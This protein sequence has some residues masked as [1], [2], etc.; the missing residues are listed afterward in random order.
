MVTFSYESKT[1]HPT[2]RK[3]ILNLIPK[4]NKDSRYIKN[5]RPITLLNT[6]YKII[7]K[8][9]ANKMIPALKTLIHE[10]QRG[11]MEDRR[12]SV[13]IR[14]FL[15]I[16]YW[17]EKEDF[18]AVVL[19]L[20]FVKCF[21]KCSF[22]ILHGSLDY[23]GFG[24]VVK[25][26][27]KILYQD[28]T[29]KIQNNGNFSDEIPIQKGVHQ[30]GCCSS[31]Y[32]LVIAEI[33]AISLRQS[34]KIE[35]ITI[36][37]IHNLLNQFADDMDV[38]SLAKEESIKAIFTELEKFR[39]QSGFTISYEKS[40]LYRIGSLRFSDAQ[41]YSISEVQWTNKDITVL[42]VTITHDNNL[43][44]KNYEKL[45]EKVRAT[46]KAWD[47][48]G[49]SLEVKV[50]VVNTLIGSQFVY[51]MMVLPSMSDK[52][53]RTIENIIR[54][55]LWSGKK[56]KIAFKTLQNPKKEGGLNLVNL[57]R[58][59]TALK[60][61]WPNILLKEHQYSQVVYATMRV[62]LLQHDI[63]RCTLAPEDVRTFSF[64]Q[65]FW[66]D[67]LFAW[68]QYNY[69]FEQKIQNQIIWYN[70]RIRIK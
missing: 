49:L 36:R 10:D 42:G 6:D 28:F 45:V 47:N 70:S 55:Y 16:M 44:E 27:T 46:V 57:Q 54:D 43:M 64:G 25:E 40:Q 48:R 68:S 34:T 2:A 7:E 14:K 35:G 67:V 53:I 37:D 60:A 38:F 21:D 65:K 62:S 63:W 30:G 11:F 18:E 39:R 4:P 3:G 26:W 23:F 61:T 19:S 24:S 15:D 58:K 50:N 13:N 69:Y 20:D 9:I 1:L 59:E 8:V 56:A 17:A 66:Q 31:I 5:L 29:V 32:F 52:I 12:I 33:L 41:M 51:K 22:S